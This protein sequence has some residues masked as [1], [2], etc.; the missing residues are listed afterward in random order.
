MTYRHRGEYHKRL[1]LL[2]TLSLIAPAL[3]R[4]VLLFTHHTD[5]QAYVFYTCVVVFAIADSVRHRRLHPATMW[6][7]VFTIS[8]FQLSLQLVRAHFWLPF[9]DGIFS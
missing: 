2:A 9:V 8:V 5:V 1:I 6:G 3:A 7:A 4:I